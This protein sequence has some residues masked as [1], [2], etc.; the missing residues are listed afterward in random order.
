MQKM[1][2]KGGAAL[3]N[4]KRRATRHCSNKPAVAVSAFSFSFLEYHAKNGQLCCC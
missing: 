4:T 3:E 2:E 1:L